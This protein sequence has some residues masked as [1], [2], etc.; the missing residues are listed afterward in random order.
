MSFSLIVDFVD[1]L[2]C[3]EDIPYT[4]VALFMAPIL[5]ILFEIVDNDK[6]EALFNMPGTVGFSSFHKITQLAFSSILRVINVVYTTENV[7]GLLAFP[8]ILL[9]RRIGRIAC[10]F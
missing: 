7:S 9:E 6:S 8:L 3:F 2:S 4:E 1:V 5:E 10:S